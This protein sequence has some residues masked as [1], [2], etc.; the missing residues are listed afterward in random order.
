MDK[1]KIPV[2]YIEDPHNKP[3][4]TCGKPSK[5]ID[6]CSEAHFCSKE[7]MDEFYDWYEDVVNKAKEKDEGE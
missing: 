7:C 4:F 5:L 3:C 2:L 1:E 6:V